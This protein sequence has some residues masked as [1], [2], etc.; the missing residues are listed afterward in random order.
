M[1]PTIKKYVLLTGPPGVGKTTIAKKIAE[2]LRAFHPVGFYTAEIRD[3]GVRKGFELVALD[4]RRRILSHVDF[5]GPHRVGKYGVDI[6]AFE[7]FLETIDLSN[8]M[9]SLIILDEIGKMECLSAK[10]RALVDRLFA[11]DRTIIATV[12]LTGGG[13]IDDIKH[14][15]EV[16]LYEV[17]MHNR[18]AIAGDLIAVLRA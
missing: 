16:S 7:R 2:A 1:N 15:P 6:D 17:T 9:H 18:N 8:P 12:A 10:F 14:R 11:S 5:S 3:K 13:L 4:G